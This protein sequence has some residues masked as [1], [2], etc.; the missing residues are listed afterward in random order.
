MQAQ[1]TKLHSP[2]TDHQSHDRTHGLS[3]A[4]DRLQH[5]ESLRRSNCVECHATW[6]SDGAATAPKAPSVGPT[7]SQPGR[8]KHSPIGCSS[9]QGAGTELQRTQAFAVAS[10]QP[11]DGAAPPKAYQA[12]ATT[13]HR[14][15]GE[16]WA[17]LQSRLRHLP[18]Q[19][20]KLTANSIH[21]AACRESRASLRREILRRRGFP[22]GGAL[23]GRANLALRRDIR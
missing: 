19:S 5:A 12:D 4:T 13:A 7:A 6:Q 22:L 18:A 14:Q 21:I 10:P 1:Q 9:A 20:L 16:W 23:A 3:G 11:I 15:I 17:V 2:V 8:P